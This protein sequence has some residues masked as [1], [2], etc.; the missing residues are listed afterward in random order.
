MT[1][2]RVCVDLLLCYV[3]LLSYVRILRHSQ[4]GWSFGYEETQ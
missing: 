3:F 1:V 2:K 4:R